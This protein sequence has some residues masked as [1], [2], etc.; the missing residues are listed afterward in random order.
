MG[1]TEAL[2]QFSRC[3]ARI[4]KESEHFIGPWHKEHTRACF[5]FEGQ[6]FHGEW[7]TCDDVL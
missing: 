4:E 5:V 1:M 2:E 7:R 3:M 6:L